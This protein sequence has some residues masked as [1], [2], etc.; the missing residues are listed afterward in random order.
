MNCAAL[1][2]TSCCRRIARPRWTSS[3]SRNTPPNTK[4][5]TLTN[6]RFTMESNE[7]QPDQMKN[8]LP[9]MYRD[10]F[11]S[12][13]TWNF[14]RRHSADGFDVNATLYRHH[15]ILS[16][17]GALVWEPPSVVLEDIPVEA[18][19]VFRLVTPKPDLVLIGCGD[20]AQPVPQA[21]AEW[22]RDNGLRYEVQPT[23]HAVG[24][25]NAV[26][27]DD[28]SIMGAFILPRK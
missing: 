9:E 1:R 10:D 23:H 13:G 16:R 25:W 22:F 27:Q 7:K 11:V 8:A 5:D 17:H 24:I 2:M 15:M 6:N 12:G 28:R 19:A 3:S 20:E 14:I 4:P 26:S 21:W 18:L